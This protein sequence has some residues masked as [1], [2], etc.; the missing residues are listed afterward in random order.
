MNR[1]VRACTGVLT[2]LLAGQALA[3]DLSQ[4]VPLKEVPNVLVYEREPLRGKTPSGESTLRL[5][6]MWNLV[7]ALAASATDRPSVRTEYVIYCETRRSMRKSI[8]YEQHD[9]QGSVIKEP[10][11]YSAMGSIEPQ[12]IDEAIARQYCRQRGSAA[13]AK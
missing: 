6:A 2:S 9:L 7:P 3:A 12:S 4:W 1:T 13:D 11:D 8:V 5:F 10:S